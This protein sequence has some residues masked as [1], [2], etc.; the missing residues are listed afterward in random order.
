MGNSITFLRFNV[1]PYLIKNR[2]FHLIKY[3]GLKALVLLYL[4]AVLHWLKFD[5]AG[6]YFL[7]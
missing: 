4:Q 6:Q 1:I 7:N 2:K 5:K 3:S